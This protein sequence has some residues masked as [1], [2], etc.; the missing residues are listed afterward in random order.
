MSQVFH[1]R[2]YDIPID[3]L[4]NTGGGPETFEAISDNHL[5]LLQQYI[6]IKE[7]DSVMEIGCGI[8]R[9]AIP[10]TE[11]L[12]R[13]RYIGTDTIGPS[14]QWCQKNISERFPNFSFVHHD[15]N[16]T[17][18]NP[19]GTLRAFDIR[20]PADE[21]SVDL[22]I[23]QSVFTHM[24]H[25]EIIHYM[26][27]FSRVLKPGG[28]V[29]TTVFIIDE[30]ILANIRDNAKTQHALSFKHQYGPGCNINTRDEPRGAVAFEEEKLKMMIAAGG[31][32]LAAPIL[33]GA[34]SGQ[35]EEPKCGQDGLILRKKSSDQ[36]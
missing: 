15:I 27:E 2:G 10:L 26:K 23:L 35:R 7:T 34:W 6:G 36:G 8:G 9:D 14:I 12:G 17:L 29:W 4:E 11:L 18:H 5:I 33:W 25:D 28:K 16:D 20:L 13:G 3:L 21:G 24:F 19:T 31:L 1:F 22:I 30:G 32:E